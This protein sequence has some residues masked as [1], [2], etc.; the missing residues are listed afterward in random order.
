MI[1]PK[2]GQKY[3][4]KFVIVKEDFHPLLGANAIQKMALITVNNEKF[5]M[6]AKVSQVY[7]FISQ[8]SDSIINEFKDV[9][10]EELGRLPGEVHLEVDSGVIPNVA[11]AR[12]IPVALKDNL[13]V[14]LEKLVKKKVIEP[15]SEP[16]PWVSAL[17]LV[18]KKN[19][20]LRLCIDPR[21]LN[22]ALKRE[23]FQLPTLDD[24]QPELADSK[25]I[26][27]LDLRDGFWQVKLDEA[28]SRL[29]TFTTPFGRFQWKVLPFGIAPAPKIFQKALFN[30]MSDLEGV[31]NRAND[32]LV[33]G[34]GKTMEEATVDH[35][36]KLRKLLRRCRDRGMRLDAGKLNLRQTS[37]SFLGHMITSDGL[38]PDPE[39]VEAI[40]EMACP[41][42]VKGVQ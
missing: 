38:L 28:S 18:A 36:I 22:K 39:K 13:K 30:N 10:K 33:I 16:T 27:N 11:A 4:V 14:E 42:D 6:V 37:I 3:A 15:V 1:N 12:R 17:A 21:P 41:T 29:T 20:N 31:I 23:Y 25:V 19:G 35:D 24:L 8:H 40:K 34:K 2:T 5:K 26:F 7:E 32:L 9:F